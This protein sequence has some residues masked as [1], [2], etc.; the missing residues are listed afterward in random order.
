M[1][2][3]LTLAPIKEIV[4]EPIMMELDNVHDAIRLLQKNERGRQGR[5]RMLYIVKTY[6]QEEMERELFQKIKD[7]VIK[8][9]NREQQDNEASLLIQ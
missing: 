3:H 9:K 1:E 7:G 5:Y 2:A 6:K 8:E 4:T